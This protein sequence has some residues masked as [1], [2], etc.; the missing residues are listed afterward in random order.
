MVCRFA[1]PGVG[2]TTFWKISG[3]RAGSRAGT[4]RDARSFRG[5]ARRMGLRRHRGHRRGR[6]RE[7]NVARAGMPRGL[8]IT[9]KRPAR[10]RRSSQKFPARSRRKSFRGASR[11]LVRN[12]V[13]VED[14]RP[15]K[16]KTTVTDGTYEISANDTHRATTAPPERRSANLRGHRHRFGR[17]ARLDTTFRTA[18]VFRF[19]ET[20]RFVTPRTPRSSPSRARLTRGDSMG[21]GGREHARA[22]PT[23]PTDLE[24][25]EK[26]TSA[27]VGT[28]LASI[29][30]VLSFGDRDDASE[31]A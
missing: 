27:L 26:H 12:V 14:D 31:E 4:H 10:S 29:L 25:V 24:T 17:R 7:E 18:L 19:S 21:G 28:I 6:L 8:W 9:K 13:R 16:I 2:R 1:N 20:E 3:A 11:T 30:W 5:G 23:D 15:R 22:E